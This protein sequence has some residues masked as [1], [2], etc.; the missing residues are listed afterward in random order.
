M[1]KTSMVNFTKYHQ[2]GDMPVGYH[3]LKR[4][5]RCQLYILKARGDCISFI[6]NEIFGMTSEVRVMAG[7]GCIPDRVDIDERPSVDEKRD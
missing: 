5:Q 7:R 6:V 1:T 3:H 4:D 2:G